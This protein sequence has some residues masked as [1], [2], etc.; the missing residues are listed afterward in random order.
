MSEPPRM[1]QRVTVYCSSSN[2][3]HPAYFDA[4]DHLGSLLAAE[5]WDLVYGGGSVGLMGRTAA[6]VREGDGHVTGII[7]QRLRD[8]EQ[9]DDLNDENIVVE[10]MRERKRLLEQRGDAFVILPGGLGTLEEF[11]E[12]LVG[13]LLGEHSKPIVIFNLADP[14]RPGERFYDPLLAMFDHMIASRMARR[15]VLS[16]F[17]VVHTPD[18]VIE[19]LRAAQ[20]RPASGRGRLDLVP[21]PPAALRPTGDHAD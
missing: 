18:E 7:T 5:G 2:D 20:S 15:G 11:F 12:I 21:S 3:L 6:A 17:D 8:A 13:H 14:D 16:L 9:M 1:I 4:A 10:T 19:A